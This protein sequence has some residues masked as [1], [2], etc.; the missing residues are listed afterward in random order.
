[1]NKRLIG[2][3][4]AALLALLG[5]I[6]ILRYVNDADERARADVELV[7]VYV[8]DSRVAAGADEAEIRG[9]IGTAQVT[10]ESVLG[11]VVTDLQQLDGKVAAVDLVPGEQVLASRFID[12]AS[13]NAGKSR[14][15]SV[16]AGLQE[17][18]F[19]MAP[20]R[21]VGGQVNPGDTVGV[22]A[23]FGET[24][25]GGISEDALLAIDT[26][27]EYIE[28][29][30]LLGA[31]EE[32]L[33]L[34]ETTHF[35]LH[36][37]LVTR[38]QV[39]ELPQEVVD[40]DGNPVDTG[41]LSPTGNLLVTLAVQTEDVERL[42]FSAEFGSI[43]MSYEPAEA[44]GHEATEPTNRNNV[45]DHPHEDEDGAEEF[46]SNDIADETEAAS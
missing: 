17:I 7:E 8:V 20:E 16:P 10:A 43:W 11:D 19:S 32:D 14:L 28:L 3:A 9:S 33:T 27:E 45:F 30:N 26:Y 35:L 21:L 36:K 12:A 5:T 2:V 29:A 24:E 46:I 34:V 44:D 22:I 42:V 4:I 18:T 37:V 6:A 40:A 1:M 38:V 31:V 13:Y 23:S 41:V 15:T 39:E 25:L